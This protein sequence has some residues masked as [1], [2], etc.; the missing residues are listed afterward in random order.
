MQTRGVAIVNIADGDGSFVASPLMATVLQ[1][2]TGRDK[3]RRYEVRVGVW[4]TLSL[5]I[6]AM[7]E[8][9]D[10]ER[11]VCFAAARARAMESRSAELL[12]ASRENSMAS[13]HLMLL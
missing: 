1:G 10:Q 6:V 7:S 4:I 12:G 13:T 8:T 2:D 3:S 5:V 11:V 9:G